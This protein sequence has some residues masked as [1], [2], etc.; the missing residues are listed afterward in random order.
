VIKEY[1][2]LHTQILKLW[3]SENYPEGSYVVYPRLGIA[4][5]TSKMQSFSLMGKGALFQ[6][7]T[8]ADA[9]A[10]VNNEVHIIEYHFEPSL[11]K[12]RKLEKSEKA[13]RRTKR[14]E[15]LYSYPI[16]KIFIVSTS[17]P[18]ME[19][20][21]INRGVQIIVYNPYRIAEALMSFAKAFQK[22]SQGHLP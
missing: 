15:R 13:F 21:A 1:Y 18:L 9:I 7:E 2:Q 5:Q 22:T 17:N 10:F 19:I 6:F 8:R 11:K 14:F 3:L 20:E 12:I 4:K 16:R